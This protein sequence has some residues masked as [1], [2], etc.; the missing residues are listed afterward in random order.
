MN[1]LATDLANRDKMIQLLREEAA[2]QEKKLMTRYKALQHTAAENNF[3]EGVVE[4]YKSY[5]SRIK[6]QKEEQYEALRVLYDHIDKITEENK[7]ANS[8][9]CEIQHDQRRIIR[10]M[11]QVNE[12]MDNIFLNFFRSINRECIYITLLSE[13][14]KTSGSRINI[15]CKRTRTR[16]TR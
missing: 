6:E 3:L 9:L 13:S 12:E 15:I 5:Y 11:R 14:R 4:D 8:M 7:M 10:E 16:C 1:D 2:N